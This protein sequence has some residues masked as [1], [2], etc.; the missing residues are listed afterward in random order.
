MQLPLAEFNAFH[1][2]GIAL[3]S[4]AVILSVLGTVRANFP[5][6]DGAA[7][8]IMAITAVLVVGTIGAAIGTAEKHEPDG[9]GHGEAANPTHEGESP[10]NA[11][12]E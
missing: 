3:A 8:A 5:G 9:A 7:R 12:D 1:G 4:W 11:P 2:I 10:E 6:N